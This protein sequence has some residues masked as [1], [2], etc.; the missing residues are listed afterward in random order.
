[1]EDKILYYLPPELHQRSCI[2]GGYAVHAADAGDIDLF[3]LSG[4]QESMADDAYRMATHLKEL[5]LLS[6]FTP[7]EMVPYGEETNGG[8]FLVYTVKAGYAGKDV[9]LLVCSAASPK[10]LID[11]FDLSVHQLAYHPGPQ[12]GKITWFGKDYTA[13]GEPI[14][15]TR[16]D[17]PSDT[18]RRLHKL[19][20]RYNTIADQ[21][22]VEKLVRLIGGE[23]ENLRIAA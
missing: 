10:D 20:Q 15:V 2:A 23:N 17:T 7:M 8:R 6:R 16:F 19:T 14:R 12:G 3:V 1:M 5:K 9:Q 4:S 18:L 22:D 11:S 13:P 21:G